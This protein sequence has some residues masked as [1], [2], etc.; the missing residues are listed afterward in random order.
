M[1]SNWTKLAAAL[2]AVAIAGTITFTFL[3]QTAGVAYA[4]EQTLEA[5]LALRY[6]HVRSEPAGEGFSEA[7]AELG[8]DGKLLRLRM[9]FPKTEDGAKEVVWQEDKAEVWFK[10]KGHA[11]VL[12]EKR[13]LKQFSEMMATF[14]PNVV[15][16]QLHEAQA[17][18]KVEI[19]TRNPSG[20]GKPITLVVNSK[21]SP[22][23]QVIY[24]VNSQTKLV[25]KIERY[26]LAGDERELVARVEYLEYNQKVSPG[27]FVMDVP[28][29]IMRIDWTTQEIGLSKGDLNDDQIAVKVA[30]EFFEA[31]IAKDYGRA[32]TIYSGLP[33]SRIEGGLGKIEFLRLVSV[34]DPAP[35]PD[36]SLPFLQV[37]CEVEFR[38]DGKTRV[39]E[40]KLNIQAIEGQPDRWALRGGI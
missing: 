8:E 35:H 30:R 38:E 37:P 24:Q 13:M 31:L 20:K 21:D 19:E 15:T 1:R 18:G 32:G 26:R 27:A 2:C 11:L 3:Q 29:D 40:F 33:A 10:T 39:E 25:E 6:I 23:K 34:G 17:N 28:A 12:H 7:W 4:L 22:D 36:A 9:I 5:N 14:D 16:K